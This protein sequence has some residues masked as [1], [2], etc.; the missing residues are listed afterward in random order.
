MGRMTRRKK[1]LLS[2]AL[3]GVVLIALY[4]SI[5][6]A[7]QRSAARSREKAN[8]VSNSVK[9]AAKKI[10]SFPGLR[11]KVEEDGERLKALKEKMGAWSSSHDV[12][13][14]LFNEAK[15]R[16]AD[17]S[18]SRTGDSPAFR[19]IGES[20]DRGREISFR[21]RMPCSYRSFAEYVEAVE[22]AGETIVVHEISLRRQEAAAKTL[23]GELIVTA[24]LFPQSHR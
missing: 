18:I 13:E 17:V 2:M 23:M 4:F 8:A 5:F 3:S 15:E 20:E 14:A 12:A 6:R 21:I 11:R 24:I 7:P 10:A 9:D 16:Q 22:N 1:D 19:G